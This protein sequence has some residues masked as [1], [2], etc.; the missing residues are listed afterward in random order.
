MWDLETTRGTERP[1]PTSLPT[2]AYFLSIP[3]LKNGRWTISEWAYAV[4]HVNSAF[5]P[6]EF[7]ITNYT[8]G[9]SL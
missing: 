8:P 7:T 3:K 2:I 6:I 9:I 5:S 1:I 4:M